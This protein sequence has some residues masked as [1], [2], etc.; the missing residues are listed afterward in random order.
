MHMNLKYPIIMLAAVLM[1]ACTKMDHTYA[2]YLENGEQLYPGVPY[3]L[4]T[5]PGRERIEVQFTQSKD[6]NIV[7]YVLYWNNG[8]R[9]MEVNADRQHPVMK[10]IIPG[11]A[12]GDY[13][14]DIVSVYK[15][16][17]TSTPKS[18]I[19][20][21]RA[22]GS[23]FESEQ[24]IRKVLAVNSRKGFALEFFSVDT[25]CKYTLFKYKDSGG[26][27]R[28]KRLTGT[29]P[30]YDTLADIHPLANSLMFRT[31]YVPEKCID[32]FY[33]E[34]VVPVNPASGRYV[35]TGSMIDY[36]NASLTGAYPWNVALR[37]T[38]PYT[39]ELFDEDQTKDV[40]H[41]ILSGGSPSSYGSFGVVLQLDDQH[42]V[43]SVINKYGQPASNGRSAELDPSG[44]NK[45]DPVAKE[46]KV[47]YWMNQPGNT[48]RTSFDEIL[49]MK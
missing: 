32:T 14:F 12:E 5:H 16:G 22:L 18:A 4:E 19:V 1:A 2:P 3:Q 46:L 24:F 8:Q 26:A 35:C 25:T 20:S 39:L 23:R 13:T 10:V 7:K 17:N 30:S 42:R 41:K 11:L 49:T 31:A 21:G 44:V 36:T 40:F 6:P 28:E 37:Q 45:Y 34:A 48:H 27:M 47:K 15:A 43:V 33:S 9:K 38:G 29:V